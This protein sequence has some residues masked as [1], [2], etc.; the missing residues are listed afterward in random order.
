M[1]VGGALAVCP[2]VV[3]SGM[4]GRAARTPTEKWLGRAPCATTRCPVPEPRFGTLQPYPA[5]K[6]LRTGC[7]AGGLGVLSG[8]LPG[9]GQGR[10]MDQ[11]HSPPY[12]GPEGSAGEAPGAPLLRSPRPSP[13]R[14]SRPSQPSRLPAPEA[15]PGQQEAPTYGRHCH[16]AELRPST[17]PSPAGHA[18]SN[19]TTGAS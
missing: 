5:G 15:A 18:G 9:L 10:D 1:C 14:K 3:A 11:F 7:S 19:P 8:R 16:P 4:G 13:R 6:P 12:R 2:A 17:V